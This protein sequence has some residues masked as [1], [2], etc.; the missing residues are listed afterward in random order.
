MDQRGY[1]ESCMSICQM[2]KQVYLRITLHAIS[3]KDQNRI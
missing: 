2:A 3:K 1:E